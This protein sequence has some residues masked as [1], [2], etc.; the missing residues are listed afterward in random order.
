M[1]SRPVWR[2]RRS[3]LPSDDAQAMAEWERGGCFSVD[4]S[5]RIAAADHAG[6]ERLLRFCARP[7]FSLDRLRELDPELLLDDR[8]KPRPGGT[9][10]LRLMPLQELDRLAA[11]VP[12]LRFHAS[13]TLVRP[14]VRPLTGSSCGDLVRRRSA[15]FMSEREPF[16]R[17]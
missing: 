10:P 3:L 17:R 15:T 6:R 9:G 11:L 7:P 13:A 5:V 12:P 14:C 8:A 4:A 16:D 2:V 1:R